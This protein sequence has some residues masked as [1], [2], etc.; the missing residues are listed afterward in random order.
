MRGVKGGVFFFID[1][2]CGKTR[3]ISPTL[4]KNTIQLK[5]LQCFLIFLKST[6]IVS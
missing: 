6:Y 4:R 1:S 5:V 2:M 3:N